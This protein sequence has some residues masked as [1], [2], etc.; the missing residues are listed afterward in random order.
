[1][2]DYHGLFGYIRISQSIQCFHYRALVKYNHVIL[3]IFCIFAIML[4]LFCF[5][6]K[7]WKRATAGCSLKTRQRGFV[8]YNDTAMKS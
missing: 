5:V 4:A 1:M 7:V 8:Y 3:Y 2:C 6:F